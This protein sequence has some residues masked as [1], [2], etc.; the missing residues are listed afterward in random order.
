MITMMMMSFICSCRNKN[1]SQAPY[2]PLG[3]YVPESDSNATL[4]DNFETAVMRAGATRVTV[5]SISYFCQ[6]SISKISKK[7]CFLEI[8][9]F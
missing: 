3:R 2:I 1:R 9:A 8:F 5:R 7:R 4:C 6:S